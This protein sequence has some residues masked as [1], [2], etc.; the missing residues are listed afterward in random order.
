MR[1]TLLLP[2]LGLLFIAGAVPALARSSATT[3]AEI[4]ERLVQESIDAYLGSCP[5]PYSTMRN[6]RRC[7]GRSA[8]SR[9]GGQS[10]LC[11][12]DDVPSALIDAYRGKP[13][14]STLR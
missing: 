14:S 5:C 11:Y 3:D 2:W 6:G 4:R 9:P 10:P 1:P 8:Y 13:P 12:P 7:G